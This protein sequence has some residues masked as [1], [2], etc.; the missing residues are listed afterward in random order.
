MYSI[1]FEENNSEYYQLTRCSPFYKE[2]TFDVTPVVT[3]DM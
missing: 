2:S 3:L 1:D